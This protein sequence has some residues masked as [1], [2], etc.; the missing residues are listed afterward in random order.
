ML[1][2]LAAVVAG[3]PVDPPAP[4]HEQLFLDLAREHRVEQL[5]AWRICAQDRSLVPWFGDA[6]DTL[7]QDARTLS[8][9]DAVRNRE[10]TAIVASLATVEGAQPLLF[11]G[12][13]LAHSHYPQSWLRPR[14]DT[15][16]LISPASTEPVFEA[17]RAAGYARTTSTSGAFV[18]SQASFTRTD[19]Y[20]V[21]HALDVHWR[22][23][24]WQIIARVSTHADL[25]SRSVALP[26]LGP[27]ARTVSEPDALLLACLHRA[28]HHRDSAELLWLYDI[29]LIAQRLTA[30]DWTFLAAAAERGAVKAICARGMSLA[31]DYFGSRVPT[32]VMNRLAAGDSEPSAIYLSKDVRLVDGLWSDLRA[33]PLRDRVRLLSEHAFPPAEYIRKKYGV[34]SRASLLLSYARRI[35][36]GVPRWFAPGNWS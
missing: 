15:D 16:L 5:A 36:A 17:L 33:L 31:S 13:A 28:A 27:S 20:G 12:A 21:T 29:H 6:A 26:A 10:I 2:T 11:K 1:R 4:G 14:L 23:A 9:V 30:A 7:R 35:A 19:S 3:E 24:N 18:V 32:E 25:A 34:T 8:L 22:I